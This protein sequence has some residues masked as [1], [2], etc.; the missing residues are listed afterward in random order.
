MLVNWLTQYQFPI[1]RR[2]AFN[3]DDFTHKSAHHI[4]VAVT[5]IHSRK[6]VLNIHIAKSEIITEYFYCVTHYM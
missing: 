4:N 3:T 1:I 2:A 6:A 5:I